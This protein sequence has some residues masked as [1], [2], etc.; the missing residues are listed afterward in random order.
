MAAHSTRDRGNGDAAHT[1]P[2]VGTHGPPSDDADGE[3]ASLESVLATLA[4]SPAS[5]TMLWVPR[6]MEPRFADIAT[7]ALNTVVA[8]HA[9][10]T[11]GAEQ[12]EVALHAHSL[13]QSLP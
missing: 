3:H 5:P 6:S 13:L 7:M 11:T 12:E 10:V 2:G 4:E 9:A 8:A 1:A